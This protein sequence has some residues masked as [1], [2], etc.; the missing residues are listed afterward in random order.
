MS[1]EIV[2]TQKP[3]MHLNQIINVFRLGKIGKSIKIEL[4]EI[5]NIITETIPNIVLQL[6]IAINFK[7]I[8]RCSYA[9]NTET[10]ESQV[11]NQTNIL[12]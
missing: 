4:Y 3:L 11:F 2:V 6:K 9:L 5:L 12:K 8:H 1:L 10:T 7:N